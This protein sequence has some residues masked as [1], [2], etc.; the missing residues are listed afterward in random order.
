MTTGVA[1]MNLSAEL[2]MKTSSITRNKKTKLCN[3][4]RM[5]WVHSTITEI[6]SFCT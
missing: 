3:C 5:E 6:G 1:Q 2:K 4:N